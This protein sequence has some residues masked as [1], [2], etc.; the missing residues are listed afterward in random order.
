[1]LNT[2]KEEERFKDLQ[3]LKD[4]TSPSP[5]TCKDDVRKFMESCGDEKEKTEQIYIEVRY[6]KA[7]LWFGNNKTM[8]RLKKDGKNLRAEEY[9][10]D[11]ERYFEGAIGGYKYFDG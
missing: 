11:L 5:F 9:Q 6:G 8:F 1:M 3:F 4:Q 7:S 10:D 2:R